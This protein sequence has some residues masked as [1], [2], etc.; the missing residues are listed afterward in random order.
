MHNNK[1]TVSPWLI[2]FRVLF[3]VC[4]VGTIIFIFRNSL[5]AAEI[6]S[7]RSLAIMQKINSILSRLGITEGLSNHAVRKAAHFLEY[8]LEGFWLMLCTRVYTRHFVR[9]ISWP[10]L[11][12]LFTALCDETL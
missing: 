5:Q 6:S 8:C 7:A 9:H 11:G 10:M 2:A 4:L 3:T 1:Q 12:A